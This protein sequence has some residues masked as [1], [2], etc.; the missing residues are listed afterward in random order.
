MFNRSSLNTRVLS[1][2]EIRSL[3]PSVFADKPWPG[4]S[5]KYRFI[6]TNT[7]VDAM[8]KEGFMPVA[9]KQSRTRIEGKGDFTKHQL[10]FRHNDFAET[11]RNFISANSSIQNAP[12][13]PELILTNS[14]DG[15]S[16]YVLD[17]GFFRLVC[18]NGLM[19]KSSS[20]ESI[21][22]RHSGRADLVHDVIEGSFKVI[23]EAPKAIEQIGVWKSTMLDRKEQEILANAALAVRETA[24]DI[25]ETSLLR[26]RRHADT[27]Y[28]NGQRDAW[29]TMNVVQ[30]NLV[31]GGVAGLDSKHRQR[32]L[33]GIQAIDSDTKLNKA[34]WML[35]EQMANLKNGVTTPV[36]A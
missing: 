19:V 18:S 10:R 22:S 13:I 11:L 28:E 29:R 7:V 23:E 3:A 14:H 2:D 27:A 33:R 16:G 5:D 8:M 32:R 21:R 12:E 34:L 17:L 36:T 30:E 35:T 24:L 26:P 20:I 25:G 9:A 6:P 4:M 1:L 15:A 31:R